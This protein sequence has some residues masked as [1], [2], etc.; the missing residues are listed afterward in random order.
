M[1]GLIE[2][3]PDHQQG[4]MRE[5]FAGIPD[6]V[7][8]GMMAAV[9]SALAR[10]LRVGISW[11]PGYDYE[12]RVWDVSDGAEGMVNVHLISPHPVETLPAR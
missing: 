6:A 11:Q 5:F 1:L 3:L 7:D 8:A 12:L 2:V 10:G 9:R 4:P